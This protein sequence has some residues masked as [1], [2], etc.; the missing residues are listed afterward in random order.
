M[1]EV[2]NPERRRWARHAER[3]NVPFATEA[4]YYAGYFCF[5]IDTKMESRY[6]N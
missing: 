6:G 1:L 2:L 4:S 5:E 3:N